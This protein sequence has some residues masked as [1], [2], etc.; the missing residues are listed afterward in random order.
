[1]MSV[2]L[3][4]VMVCAGLLDVDRRGHRHRRVICGVVGGEG[5][6]EELVRTRIQ[7]EARRW[8]EYIVPRD[9]CHGIELRL[10][11]RRAGRDARGIGPRD[12]RCRLF[13]VDQDAGGGLVVVECGR[14]DD[15]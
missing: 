8:R 14:G 6:R 9:R 13:D 2:G 3:V 1:M 15:G 12:R 4:Q 11:E 10:A 7:D 5:H